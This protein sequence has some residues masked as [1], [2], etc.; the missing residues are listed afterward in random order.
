MSRKTFD[1]PEQI[2]LVTWQDVVRFA[3]AFLMFGIAIGL[4]L[5]DWM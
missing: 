5:D 2:H 4:C 3:L 1:D